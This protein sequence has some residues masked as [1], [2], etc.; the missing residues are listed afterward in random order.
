MKVRVVIAICVLLIGLVGCFNA[1]AEKHAVNTKKARP[2]VIMGYQF[3][4]EG[5]LIKASVLNNGSEELNIDNSKLQIGKKTLKASIES[6]QISLIPPSG[7]LLMES[8]KGIIMVLA[9]PVVNKLTGTAISLG[10]G[11]PVIY[12]TKGEPESGE[13]EWTATTLIKT[14]KHT[15]YL[16]RVS[17]QPLTK[18][19]I[20]KDIAWKIVGSFKEVR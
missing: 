12:L 18:K 5:H 4:I 14:K 15:Y 19:N 11:K 3:S 17:F 13:K 9:D 20:K 1:T 10:K 2:V 8:K 16:Q 7:Q 6:W